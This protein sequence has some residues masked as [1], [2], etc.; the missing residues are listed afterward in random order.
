MGPGAWVGVLRL[1]AD[2]PLPLLFHEQNPRS[3]GTTIFSTLK[4][5]SPHPLQAIT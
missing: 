5:T 4:I 3:E 2:V 1:P